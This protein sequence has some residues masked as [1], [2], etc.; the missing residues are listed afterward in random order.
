MKQNFI[1]TVD[2]ETA[3]KM[4]SEGF[5][6]ISQIGGVYTFLNLPPQS[7]NFEAEEQKKVIYTNMLSL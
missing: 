5:Q 1:K 7:F 6:L 3:H 4:I 2:K